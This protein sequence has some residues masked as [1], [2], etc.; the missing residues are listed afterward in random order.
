[1]ESQD[2][3]VHGTIKKTD[4]TTK[5]IVVKTA[6]GTEHTI[7][8]TEQVTVHGTKESFD[9]LKEESEAVT[10]Y[11]AN[12]AEKNRCELGEVGKDESYQRYDNQDRPGGPLPT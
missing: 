2:L 8:V 3:I 10:R 4:K 1:V 12:G 11:R 9:D 5:A 7:K 6:D